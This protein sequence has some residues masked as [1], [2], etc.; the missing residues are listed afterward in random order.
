M[1]RSGWCFRKTWVLIYV[2]MGLASPRARSIPSYPTSPIYVP[3]TKVRQLVALLYLIYLRDK[4][5][6]RISSCPTDFVV[7][8]TISD[9]T[10][11]IR[12]QSSYNAVIIPTFNLAIMKHLTNLPIGGRDIAID[13]SGYVCPSMPNYCNSVSQ[14]LGIIATLN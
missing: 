10:F 4:N 2:L 3:K 1:Q 14:Y 12:R 5:V 11:K 13:M 6:R 8:Y 7:K 9:S